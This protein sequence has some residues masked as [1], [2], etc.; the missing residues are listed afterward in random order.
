MPGLG[1]G[2]GGAEMLMEVL[3]QKLAEEQVRAQQAQFTR[4]LGHDQARLAQDADQFSV[5]SAQGNRRLDQVDADLG[6]RKER[7]GVDDQRY[8]EQAPLRMANVRHLNVTSDEIE[9]KPAAEEAARTFTTGRDK[10]QHG[11]QMEEGA[12]AGRNALAVANV[13]HPDTASAAAQEKEDNEIQDSLDVIAQL[14]N[15]KALPTSTG[16]IQGRGAGALW[17]LEGFERVKSLH[18]NLVNK[19]SLAQAGKLKGQGPVSNFERDMLA[20][21][22][23]ALKMQLGDKDYLTQ[24]DN[25]EQFFK[26]QQHGPRVGKTV[27]GDKPA[28]ADYRKKYNY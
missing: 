23:T 16:P 1:A 15:D 24:L 25:V 7:S 11:Y 22:A 5:S 6:F 4:R 19:L 26:R 9:R 3:R 8:A 27:S 17:G 2:A 14:R 21:A 18:D 28:S 10:T 20:K 12:Q 13:R